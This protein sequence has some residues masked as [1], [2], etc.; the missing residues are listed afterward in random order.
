MSG[1]SWGV[2]RCRHESDEERRRGWTHLQHPCPAATRRAHIADV[3]QSRPCPFGGPGPPKKLG[4]SS[5]RRH[6]CHAT[7]RPRWFVELAASAYIVH[8]AV[9]SQPVQVW[10]PLMVLLLLLLWLYSPFTIH[11]SSTHRSP[12]FFCFSRRFRRR[13]C[14][15][16]SA[17]FICPG[18]LSAASCA[19][20]ANRRAAVQSLPTALCQLLSRHRRCVSLY[21]SPLI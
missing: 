8:S 3:E 17:H 1:S 15:V 18:A 12:F 4:T 7:A 21:S 16:S 5:Q 2:R 19:I 9:L 13:A 10:P 20:P 11:H 6:V 14:R